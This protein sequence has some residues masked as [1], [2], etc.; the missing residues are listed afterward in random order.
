MVHLDDYMRKLAVVNATDLLL[1]AGRPPLYR[2]RGEL[3]PLPGEGVV[4][5][6]ALR[7]ELETLLG[8]DAWETLQQEQRVAFSCVLRAG[9]RIRGTCHVSAHGLTVKLSLLGAQSERL[10]ELELPKILEP[11]LGAQ[12][13]MVIIT[14]PAGSGKTTLIA[15]VVSQLAAGRSL[16]IATSEDPVEYRLHGGESIVVQRSIGRHCASHAQA[17]DTALATQAQIIACSDLAAPRALEGMLEAAN[18]GV[19]ALGELP[20]YGVVRA[21]EQ[22]VLGAPQHA[23]SQLLVDLADALLAV[24]SL[25][26][27]PRKSGG[28]VLAVEVLLSTR[29]VCSLVRDGKLSLLS[30]LLDRE[31]GMQSMDRSLLDLATRGVVE[32]REAYTRAVDKRLLSAWS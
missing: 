17:I 12:S 21:L 22:L 13:G 6:D 14:G 19:L 3:L 25:D 15:R 8:A 32:G 4:A 30:G 24:V 26:L 31:P 18:A 28:R 20:G 9:E 5:D 23:R 7:A 29:N 11:L 16:H 10:A 1:S 27:L 2:A